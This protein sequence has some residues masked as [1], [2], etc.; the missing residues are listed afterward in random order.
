MAALSCQQPWILIG[1][2]AA[3]TIPPWV[4]LHARR[5]PTRVFSAHMA[6]FIVLMVAGQ[7]LTS[8]SAG[9]GRLSVVASI[10]LMMGV[11]TRS[12]IVPALLD[13]DLFDHAS[14]G[15]SLLFFTPMVGAYAAVR[16][17]LPI[18]PEWVLHAIA[19][20]SLVTA[21]TQPAMALVQ[22]DVRRFFA[23]FS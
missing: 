19:C 9:G 1:L 20:L 2:L 13:D 21:S 3:G 18:A 16:L 14:L 22:R 5:M 11:L 6:L 10:L 4:E 15:T 7:A 12:G 17:V 8:F 23:I